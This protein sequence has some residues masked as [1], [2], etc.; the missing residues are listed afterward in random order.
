LKNQIFSRCEIGLGVEASSFDGKLKN[1]I[2]QM[3]KKLS[4]FFHNILLKTWKT[5]T[6]KFGT[7]FDIYR[8]TTKK[9]QH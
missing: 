8:I 4:G 7:P 3:M 9:L 6:Y 1:N 2:Y 5:I